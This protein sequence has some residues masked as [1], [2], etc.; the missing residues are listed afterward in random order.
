MEAAVA[1]HAIRRAV[2]LSERQAYVG[3]GCRNVELKR[4]RASLKAELKAPAITEA[5]ACSSAR[6]TCTSRFW[7]YRASAQS[8]RREQKVPLGCINDHE[9]LSEFGFF[10]QAACSYHVDRIPTQS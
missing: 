3:A 8:L 10:H 2:T 7:V 9:Q 1:M 4:M 6:G 5:L